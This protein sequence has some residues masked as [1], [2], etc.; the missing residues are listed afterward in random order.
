[1]KELWV[2]K[3]V[4]R[5]YL[6]EDSDVEEAK[7][8]LENFEAYKEESLEFDSVE[9]IE[10]SLD[11]NEEVEYDDEKTFSPL[12]YDFVTPLEFL[13]I[14]EHVK[15]IEHLLNEDRETINSKYSLKEGAKGF[16]KA[17]YCEKVEDLAYWTNLGVKVEALEEVYNLENKNK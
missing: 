8:L 14:E 9:E 1:M 16:F 6:I 3:T 2:K 17:V 10:N 11:R 5:R 15:P 4:Y 13:E 12:T 7:I